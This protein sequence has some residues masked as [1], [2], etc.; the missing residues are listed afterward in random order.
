MS[1]PP[2]DD[3]AHRRRR[4]AVAG[5]TGDRT[6]ALLL[7]TDPDPSVRSTALGALA[8][9]DALTADHLIDALDDPDPTVRRRAVELAARTTDEHGDEEGRVLRALADALGGDDARVVEVAAWALGERAG[10]D[11]VT[12]EPDAVL[13]DG[14]LDALIAVATR[15]DDALCREAAVAALGALGRADG[16]EAVLAATVDKPAVRRRAVIALAAFLDDQRAVAA[17]RA[18]ADDRDW[19][20]RDAAEI[21]LDDIDDHGGAADVTP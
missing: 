1:V 5:H 14:V 8:R 7:A 16:L 15:H 3:A 19:Q 9:L 2:T 12:G 17:L 13:P 18:A 11:P 6:T 21:L 20:V 4:A 10:A